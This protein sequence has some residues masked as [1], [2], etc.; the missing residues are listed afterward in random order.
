MKSLLKRRILTACACALGTLF[1]VTSCEDDT[2]SDLPVEEPY[3][4]GKAAL[5]YG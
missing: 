3:P 4:Y 2:S 5:I 1:F